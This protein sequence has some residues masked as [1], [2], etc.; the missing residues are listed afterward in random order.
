MIRTTGRK[1]AASYL[2]IANGDEAQLENIGMPLVHVRLWLVGHD[3]TQRWQPTLE[4]TGNPQIRANKAEERIPADFGKEDER[5]SQLQRRG[6][7]PE[8]PTEATLSLGKILCQDR[9]YL[10]PAASAYFPR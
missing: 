6:L 1:T 3:V 7:E 10:P 4:M 8:P 2:S 9:E 5:I